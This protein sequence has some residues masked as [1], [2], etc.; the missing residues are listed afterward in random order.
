MKEHD[1]IKII[2]E[3]LS[4]NSF[5][6]D[7]CAYL[8][9][10]G[11]FVTHDTMVENIHFSLEYSNPYQIGYKAV[12]TNLS[13]L[14]SSLAKPL[15]ITVSLSLPPKTTDVFI[16]ELYNGINDAC[17]FYGVKVAGGDITGA[18]K[19]I[20]SVCAFGSKQCEYSSKRN[21][22]KV[23]DVIVTTGTHGSAAAGLLCL[24]NNID[25]DFLKQKHLMPQARVDAVNV[26]LPFVKANIAGMD[27]SDG[28]YDALEQIAR[29]SGVTA[30]VD[31]STVPYDKE[32]EQFNDFKKLIL[33]GGEDYELVFALDKNLY[34]KLDK[35][36]FFKIGEIIPKNSSNVLI[37]GLN[38]NEISMLKHCS[39]DH[40]EDR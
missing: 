36:K 1:F 33:F 29:M 10:L 17:N 2:N 14:A 20:V 9:D 13:D 15:Y 23:G 6:G 16:K 22:A 24:K 21:N 32:I 31:F 35:N 12:V 19:I 3:T 11:I 39:F 4:D 34:E 26:I 27:T 38:Q 30:K 18:D 40:F 28:L 7:D 5:L 8:N 25:N 37:E